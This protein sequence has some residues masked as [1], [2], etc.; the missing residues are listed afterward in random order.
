M[1]PS[2]KRSH[3]KTLYLN[4]HDLAQFSLA[5][6]V[7]NLSESEFMRQ[8]C[9]HIVKRRRVPFSQIQ[10]YQQLGVLQQQV[11]QIQGQ[12]QQSTSGNISVQPKEQQSATEG[13]ERSTNRATTRRSDQSASASLD[14]ANIGNEDAIQ[15]LLEQI[16]DHL[17]SIKTLR[18]E[19]AQLDSPGSMQQEP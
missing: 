19:V 10:F 6:G 4:D 8:R 18:R 14:T 17:E 1:P 7:S 9:L 13:G 5:Q 15:G 2:S 3:R 16:T 11:E 12:L